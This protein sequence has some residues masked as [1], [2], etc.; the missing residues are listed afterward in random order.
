MQTLTSQDGEQKVKKAGHIALCEYQGWLLLEKSPNVIDGLLQS[1]IVY[2]WWI[3]ALP[4]RI[5]SKADTYPRQYSMNLQ[6]TIRVF[7]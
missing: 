5:S 3:K 4:R 1:V 6:L 7:F 2:S